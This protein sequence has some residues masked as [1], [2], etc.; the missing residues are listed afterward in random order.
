MHSVQLK[1]RFSAR[2]AAKEGEEEA[3]ETGE[4]LHRDR[5]RCW[6]RK[7]MQCFS[8]VQVLSRTPTSSTV[9]RSRLLASTTKSARS[10]S[11]S[12]ESPGSP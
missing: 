10:S 1:K 5:G 3:K 4:A 9:A 11:R 12:W 6:L 8:D 2:E 7:L